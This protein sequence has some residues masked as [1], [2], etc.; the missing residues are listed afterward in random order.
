MSEENKGKVEQIKIN[1][2]NF[3]A[4]VRQLVEKYNS[5]E[6]WS[7]VRVV[8]TV[9][10]MDVYLERNSKQG[11]KKDEPKDKEATIAKTPVKNNLAEVVSD[12]KENKEVVEKP[13]PKKTAAKQTTKK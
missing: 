6:G 10:S 13:A 11:E 7:V 3:D 8:P 2:R 12:E 1:G 5:S 9:L 4:V